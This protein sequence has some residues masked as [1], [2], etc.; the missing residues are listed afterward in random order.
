MA[1]PA[2]QVVANDIAASE[3]RREG[4]AWGLRM[5]YKT[6][7]VHTDIGT[8]ALE[9][10]RLAARLARTFDA[11]LIGSAL[12]GISRFIPPRV[13]AEGGAALAECCAAMRRDAAE[14]L[15]R[16]SHIVAEEAVASSEERLID[17]DVDGGMALQARYSDLVVVGQTDYN[18][19]MPGKPGDLPEYLLLNSGRPILVV[20]YV[21]CRLDLAG[22][23]LVAWD[24]SVEATRAVAGALPL[25]RR[26]HGVTVLTLDGGES[27]PLAVADPCNQMVEYL[28]RHGISARMGR[29]GYP[30]RIGDA[31][32][33][34]A[35][36]TNASLLVLGGYG[37]SRFRELLLGG[38]TATIL[39]S[40]TLPVLLAH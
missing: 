33:S 6:I 34:E 21:S 16:F 14:S 13:I 32:L 11:H 8:A 28:Q 3:L 38:V 23:A 36:D 25:L 40:M 2:P 29:R 35:A 10:V 39:R 27:F 12:T 22:D 18:T 17:D 19:F 31:L 26:A 1:S 30:Q 4:S 15:Q 5:S 9:R 37:Q 24:G 20:P 7:L